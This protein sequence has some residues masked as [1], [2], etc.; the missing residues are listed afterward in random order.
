MNTA[1][2][3]LDTDGPVVV[4]TSLFGTLQVAVG[5][6]FY[7]AQ[8]RLMV[9]EADGTNGTGRIARLAGFGAGS[10]LAQ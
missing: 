6:V 3:L 8:R 7:P 1:Q 5:T 4:D 9:V 2:H 10:I